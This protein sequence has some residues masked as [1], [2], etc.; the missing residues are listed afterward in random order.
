MNKTNL[1]FLL[2]FADVEGLMN[3]PVTEVISIAA[4][5]IKDSIL[6]GQLA[7]ADDYIECYLHNYRLM[8]KYR[9]D[10]EIKTL[11]RE[12]GFSFFMACESW[13]I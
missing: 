3:W 12:G 7:S 13:D 1:Q 5:D 6:D 11:V 4:K 2:A 10:D 8:K 9:L